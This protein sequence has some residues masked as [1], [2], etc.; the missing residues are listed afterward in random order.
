MIGRELNVSRETRDRLEV[1]AA[2][3]T[4]WTKVINL[5]STKSLEDLW[6]RH[7]LDSAQVFEVAGVSDG[8]W[9]DLGT[10]G[11][12]PGAVVAILAT[13]F[14]PGLR[15]TCVESDQRKAAFLRT[16][17]RETSSPMVVLDQRILE[18]PPLGADIVSARALAPLKDLL[19]FS[20]RH[21]APAGASVFSKGANHKEELN[22]AQKYWRFDVRQTTSWTDPDAVI[23]KIG[24]LCRA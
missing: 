15:I 4:K 6:Q 8:H 18:V 21:M 13:E 5:V 24:A 3:L 19:E 14:A 1:F 16:V 10:G 23:F 20:A 12:L 7:I 2:L 22:L 11:G 17:S 9:A